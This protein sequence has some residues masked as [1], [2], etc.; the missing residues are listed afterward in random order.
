[1]PKRFY[2]SLQSKPW[3]LSLQPQSGILTDLSK[4]NIYR[5]EAHG[6]VPTR[7][8]QGA[9]DKGPQEHHQ[10]RGVTK[11][12]P[13]ERFPYLVYNSG[14]CPHAPYVAFIDSPFELPT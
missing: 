12:R 1:M 11:D 8:K 2:C 10:S 14:P 4:I 7:I 5:M 6:T 9:H 13:Y 3:S